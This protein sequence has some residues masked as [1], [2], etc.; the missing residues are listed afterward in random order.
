[1]L[2]QTANGSGVLAGVVH[3]VPV[4][5]FTQV[6]IALQDKAQTRRYDAGVDGKGAFVIAGVVPGAYILHVELGAAHRDTTLTLG[7]DTLRLRIQLD[8]MLQVVEV[9]E[10]R[11]KVDA[12]TQTVTTLSGV[13]LQQTRGLSLGESLKGLTG[14]YTLQSGPSIS[15]P[16]IRGLTGNRVLILNNGV[17]QEGQQWGSEH[18]P[19]ID[20]FVATQLSVVKGAAAVRYGPDALSGVIL[21][22][23]APLPI[24]PGMGGELN[25]VGQSNGQAGIVSGIV[26]GALGG[27][28]R[29]LSLRAQGTAKRAGNAQAPTYYLDNTAYRE[30][31]FSLAVGYRRGPVTSNVYYSQFA[32]Q[33]GIL[34]ASAIGSVQDLEAAI[35]RGE[36][37]VQRGFAYTINRPYQTVLHQLFKAHADVDL[38]DAGMLEAT[39]AF[40]SN[41]RAEYDFLPLNRSEAPELFLRLESHTADVLWHHPMFKALKQ[42]LTGTLGT[43]LMMQGNEREYQ[44]LI[45]NFRLYHGGLFVFEKLAVGKW[46]GEFGVRYDYRWQQAFFSVTNNSPLQTPLNIWHGVSATAG[47][48]RR[49]TDYLTT[50]LNL[51]TAW[52]APNVSELYSSGV[53]QAAAA[54][55]LGNAALRPER[56]YNLSLAAEYARGHW[57]AALELFNNYYDGFVFVQPRTVP[58]LTLRGA[59]PAFD[60]AQA[61]VLMQ[62]AEATVRVELA[63][64][65]S[66]ETRN[67]LLRAWNF[68]IS[69]YLVLMPAPRTENSLRYEKPKAGQL[70]DVYLQ[71]GTTSLARQNWVPA[72]YDFAPP[73]AA[74]TLLNLEAGAAIALG[75]GRYKQTVQVSI[76]ARNLL[77]ARYRDYL[78]RF[79][80]FTDEQG[81]N[82]VLRLR[83]LLNNYTH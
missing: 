60:Y 6:R 16:I 57:A 30:D 61:N 66:L 13:Q 45:P 58:V 2:G 12:A 47:A 53:H 50:S 37:L 1:V 40:Q 49:W 4:P 21:V 25:L 9:V 59:F 11:H 38:K 73:P 62:G 24:N 72:G 10:E 54:F 55:E 15:K 77:D 39:Y 14:V 71:A 46:L 29:G 7:T 82:I 28:L 51:S 56:G 8:A 26:E 33:L 48:R 79:R 75:N 78:N 63:K 52:R 65:L 69:D 20:P 5:D 80:Y 23:P 32:T 67:S 64:G 19:E 22:D 36:P 35:A 44:F 74:Y 81:R 31:N 41:Q 68:T 83:V 42:N 70:R 17:R 3:A 27:R 18:A 76:S 34:G 43:S